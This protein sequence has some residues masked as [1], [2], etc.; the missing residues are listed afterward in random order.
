MPFPKI[1]AQAQRQALATSLV[2]LYDE[3]DA[4]LA[5]ARDINS[6]HLVDLSSEELRA[7]WS[8]L[9]EAKEQLFLT[10]VIA[11]KGEA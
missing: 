1:L 10:R 11:E 7:V 3:A 6:A 9:S 2:E 4:I 5:R 8:H